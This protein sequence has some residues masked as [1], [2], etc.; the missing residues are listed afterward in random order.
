MNADQFVSELSRLSADAVSMSDAEPSMV[1]E[2][3]ACAPHEPLRKPLPHCVDDLVWRYDCTQMHVGHLR[4]VSA[5]RPHFGGHMVGF[6]EGEL[7]ITEHDGRVSIF[8]H[9]R[10]GERLLPCARSGEAFLDALATFVSMI[11]QRDRW[12]ERGDEAARVCAERAGG[13]EY[14][15]FYL[16]MLSYLEYGAV[17]TD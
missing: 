2:A 3:F 4:F 11:F 12:L 17:E 16:A 7:V 9:E 13:P 10:F 5:P 6:W 14:E 1:D 15:E 8:E